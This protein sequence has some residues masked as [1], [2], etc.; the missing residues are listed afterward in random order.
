MA[1]ATGC[2]ALRRP[3]R[4]PAHNVNGEPMNFKQMVSRGARWGAV[5]ALTVAVLAG[6]GGGQV[7]PFRAE[8]VLAFGDEFS[9]ITDA[10][11]KYSVNARK[12]DP[13]SITTPK[14][15]IL[16]CKAS[17]LWVQ[18]VADGFSLVFPQCNPDNVAAPASRILAVPGAK[19]AD[20]KTQ[21][22]NFMASGTFTARDM[23]TMLVGGNDILELYAQY[24]AVSEADL[25]TEAQARGKLW[26]QQ[27]NRVA[28][29]GP[30]VLVVTPPDLGLSPY[31][32]AEKAKFTDI[33]RAALITR[34]LRAYQNAMGVEIINDGR[35]IGLVYGD[36]ETQNMVRFSGSFGID[37]N[38]TAVCSALL[39]NCYEETLVT[40]GSLTTWLWADSLRLGPTY[41]VRLGEVAKSRA[42]NNPF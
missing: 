11:L 21:I 32:L 30:A 33:D 35:L 10:G 34:L 3:E 22:D 19:V 4:L 39:P 12:D 18:T 1:Y 8:R 29:L 6:C 14:A 15:R 7:D 26:G 5:A 13:A 25:T 36:V 27:I 20:L 2:N 37:N 40:G 17:P 38:N 9:V 31:A 41:H 16:D 24:P 28:L 23:A 42:Q